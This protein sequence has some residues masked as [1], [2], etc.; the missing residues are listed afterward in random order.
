LRIAVLSDS[1][2]PTR[3]GSFQGRVYEE[4]ADSD[5]I[6]HAGDMVEMDAL[7]DLERFA[8]VRAV[9]GNM[10]DI[11]LKTSLPEKIVF[12]A[13]GFRIGVTH[14][15]GAPFGITRRVLDQFEGEVPF[16]RIIIHGHSHVFKVEEKRGA[17][18]INPGALVDR[19]FGILTIAGDGEKPLFERVTF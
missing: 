14:G 18:V 3:L 5:L 10:D 6:V 11:S 9:R 19:S 15:S 2:I 1:H 13:E 4:I 8:D 7:R 12:E 17:L 16:P